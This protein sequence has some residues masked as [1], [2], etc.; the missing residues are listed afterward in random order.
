MKTI[1]S[2]FSIILCVLVLFVGQ[3]HWNQK[4]SISAILHP[5]LAKMCHTLKANVEAGQPFKIAILG[6]SALGDEGK[7]FLL[8]SSKLL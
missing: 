6:S 8:K 1:I 7:E 4:T 2:I 5:K 3:L